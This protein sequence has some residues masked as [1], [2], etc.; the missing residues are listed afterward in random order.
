MT[1]YSHTIVD[2]KIVIWNLEKCNVFSDIL[3]NIFF[4]NHISN[5]NNDLRVKR[6]L[7]LPDHSVQR[8]INHITP[9]EI[10]PFIK[11]LLNKKHQ[12]MTK[13]LI[14]CSKNYQQKDLS[15]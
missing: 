12:N 1:V 15:L 4:L 3:Q 2:A 8:S 9:I 6:A 11:N 13:S 7:E 5:P 10:K 14:L